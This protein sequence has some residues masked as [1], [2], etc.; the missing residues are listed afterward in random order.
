MKN[1]VRAFVL[2]LTV[3]G[4]VAYTQIGTSATPQLSAHT[5]STMVPTCPPGTGSC[6]LGKY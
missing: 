5:H 1:I 2:A 4:S 6:G 3:T